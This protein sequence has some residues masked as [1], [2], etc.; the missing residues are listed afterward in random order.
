VSDAR[1]ISQPAV[2]DSDSRETHSADNFAKA[3]GYTPWN[4]RQAGEQ[5]TRTQA[6]QVNAGAR[7]TSWHRALIN[8]QS[9]CQLM[10]VF[11]FGIAVAR[12]WFVYPVFNNTIDEPTHIR[13]SSAYWSTGDCSVDP[14]APP[15]GKI[16][17][18][19]G[20]FLLFDERKPPDSPETRLGSVD[21]YLYEGG[22]YW[23][24]LTAARMG[25]L[26]YLL[27]SMVLGMAWGYRLGGKTVALAAPFLLSITPFVLGHSGM[28]ATDICHML[29]FALACYSFYCWIDSPTLKRAILMGIATALAF[30]TKLS[31]VVLLPV[32]YAMIAGVRLWFQPSDRAF[33]WKRRIATQ[34]VVAISCCLLS[35]WAIYRFETGSL[36][37]PENPPPYQTVNRLFGE[38]GAIHDFM[39]RMVNVP[40]P[41][42]N[43]WRGLQRL[44]VK[45]DGEARYFLGRHLH[46]RGDLRFFPLSLSVKTPLSLMCLYLIGIAAITNK[47]IK[48]RDWRP[49]VPLLASSLILATGMLSN[50]NMGLRHIMPILFFLSLAAAIG[51]GEFWNAS[52]FGR[53]PQ[54]LVAILLAGTVVESASAH[55]DYLFYFNALAGAHPENVCVESDLDWGQD[56]QRLANEIET[57]QIHEPI[58]LAFWGTALPEKHLTNTVP[59]EPDERVNG[60]VA[61]SVFN[62]KVD[63]TGYTW[64]AEYTPVAIVGKSIW[65]FHLEDVGTAKVEKR[66]AND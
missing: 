3:V 38:S 33:E 55:P 7:E 17:A 57:R 25:S 13:L 62:L 56:L 16:F 21:G 1:H 14:I 27:G 59:L 29:M 40:V 54:I 28:A 36:V 43:F 15:I 58:H 12:L 34:L 32:L 8:S 35:V 31:M 11:F 64:L 63:G 45:N 49:L 19:L 4:N 42:H 2:S 39:E 37:G 18:G 47:V 9:F 26:L 51:V 66:L 5:H 52:R 23:P 46:N 22:Q 48:Q 24:R 41:A 50:I 44:L 20:P 10:M 6:R 30:C 60:W 65:L 61:V 53:A